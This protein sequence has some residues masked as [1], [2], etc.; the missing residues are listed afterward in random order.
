M[1]S[2]RD[3]DLLVADLLGEA[4]ATPDPGFRYDVLSRTSIRARRR[5]AMSKALNQVALFSAVGLIFP[6]AGA[7]GLTWE[8]A[9]PLVM[10]TGLLVLGLAAASVSILGPR[11]V[12]A[13]S[14]AILTRA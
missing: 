10:A 6:I 1:M 12:L 4:P 13:R 14:R 11:T 8:T 7:L 2:E 3:D 5:A 9:Q